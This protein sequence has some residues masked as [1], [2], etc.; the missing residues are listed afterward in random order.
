MEQRKRK[1]QMHMAV[2]RIQAAA[3]AFLALQRKAD[4][5]RD[6]IICHFFLRKQGHFVSV[7]V[8]HK[9]N[10]EKYKLIVKP[11]EGKKKEAKKLKL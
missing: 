3:R 7:T 8:K 9:K 2:I 1:K 10:K 11:V 4:L 6:D 5:L